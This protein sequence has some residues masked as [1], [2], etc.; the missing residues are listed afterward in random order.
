MSQGF[1]FCTAL[2][3]QTQ[4]EQWLPRINQRYEIID[5]LR[6]QGQGIGEVIG[7]EQRFAPTASSFTLG[8]VFPDPELETLFAT[9]SKGK[10]GEF[11]QQRLGQPLACNVSQSWVRRQYAPRNYPP[12][13]AP[14]G[15][16]QDGALGF[17]FL[18]YP[19]GAFPADAL[20][21]M[22]TCWIGLEPCGVGAPGL[23]ILR[24][25]LTMLL[26]PAELREECVRARF[27]PEEFYRP[28]FAP[29]DAVLMRGDVL[30]RTFVTS[31]MTNDR[32]SIELRFFPAEQIP[33]RLKGDR[34]LVLRNTS[35]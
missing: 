31:G 19:D 5:P 20:L 17:D 12:L 1:V 21:P 10:A 30:H 24:Q 6:R 7:P 16:H 33:A 13:H 25:P 26:P 22:I 14:H 9:I 23:E 15:W 4:I 35:R 27:R 28:E 32:T 11:I 2:L 29:G 3:P 18:S 8:V 34:F